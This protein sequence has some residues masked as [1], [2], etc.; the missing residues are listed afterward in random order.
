MKKFLPL[1]LVFALAAPVVPRIA[2]AATDAPDHAGTTT[3][4]ASRSV[5]WEITGPMGGDVR[6]LAID[7][8][9]P[10]HLYFGTIDGQIYV[11]RDGAAHWARISSFNHPGL[12][13]DNLLIDPR[14]ANTLYAAAHRHKEP[15]GFF[16]TTDGGQTWKESFELKTESV[17]ALTQAPSDPNVLIAGT[18]HG[19]FRSQDSGATW[20]QLQTSAYP[21]IRDVESVGVDPRNAD[22]IYAGTWHLPWK[23]EDGGRTWFSVKN[24][25]IDDSDVFAIEI[26]HRNPDHVIMSACSGIYESKN[27]G[28]LFRKVQG[29]PSQSRRTRDIMQNPAQPNAIYAGTTEGFWRTLNGGDSWMLTTS[30]KLEINA[31]AVHPDVPQVI[32]IGTNNYGVM[33]SRDGGKT[34][35][36]S[37]QGYSGRRAYFILPDHDRAGRFYASTINTATGGGFFFTS[38]DG[39]ETWQPSM[40]NMPDRLITYAMLQDRNDANI[41]YL[42]TNLGMYRS[43]DRGAS[44]SPIGA[45]S[46]ASPV[47][48]KAT[49]RPARAT[50]TRRK[51][52]TSAAARQAANAQPTAPPVRS[53]DSSETA[54]TKEAQTA[55]NAAG[56]NVGTPDG[57]AGPRTVEA[58]RRFQTEK[59]LPVTGRFDDTT[60]TA[61]G[62]GGGKQTLGVSQGMQSAPIALTET[63]NTLAYLEDT[64]GS[65]ILAGTNNGLYRSADPTKGWTRMSFGPGLDARTLCVSTSTQMPQTIWAGTSKSGVLVS[66]DGGTTWEQVAGITPAAPINVIVQD[67]QRPSYIY[68]GT[69]Q[70]LLMSHDGG[71]RWVRRGGNLPYGSYTSILIN[72]NKP[73]EMFAGSAYEREEGNGVFHS[74][75]AGM[76]WKRIDPDLPSRRVWTLAFDPRDQNRILVGSHSAGVYV[77]SRSLSAAVK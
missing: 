26:D 29:I 2:R 20:E 17:F 33:V 11:S 63:I 76:T 31:I 41:L 40:R 13:I 1:L 62:L 61:L 65:V 77:A 32:Y 48:K 64:T 5:D 67:P 68:V 54:Q 50:S 22:H 27:A 37:N 28:A 49:R 34:F 74:T 6:S 21:D 30:R 72:P 43:T 51:P 57:V 24:G 75:D 45:P 25:I 36:P 58:V 39:G 16:K 42:G 59:Q 19:V 10:Q 46:V 12:Y 9:D 55:L 70:Q 14:D 35:L 3:D 56:Y 4:A 47:V 52:S 71:E 8:R 53:T 66:R 15:G 73:D 60:L 7:P 69:T 44:W 18:H 38:D 23:T